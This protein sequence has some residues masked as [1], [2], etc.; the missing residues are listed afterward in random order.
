MKVIAAL[1]YGGSSE[2]LMAKAIAADDDGNGEIGECS[3]C[4]RA[5]FLVL[6]RFRFCG[7]RWCHD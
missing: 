1:G 7:I 2:E 6:W 4:D 5:L 3:T